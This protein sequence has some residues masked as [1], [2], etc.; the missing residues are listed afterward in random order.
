[1]NVLHSAEAF[2][3]PV[4]TKVDKVR[5]CPSLPVVE[6]VVF[7]VLVVTIA[8]DERYESGCLI[9]AVTL[10]VT[11]LAAVRSTF[12]PTVAEVDDKDEDAVAGSTRFLFDRLPTLSLCR[13]SGPIKGCL[14][15]L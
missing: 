14:L 15:G 10:V 12:S 3:P 7:A 11:E 8:V 2:V 13:S 5:P 9:L 6:A 1:M 4:P